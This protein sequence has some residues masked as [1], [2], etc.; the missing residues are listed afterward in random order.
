MKITFCGAVHE[1]T[2]SCY[3]IQADN[4]SKVLVD[5]GIFQ[6]GK[7]AEDK[8]E[9]DFPFSASEIS[10]VVVTHAHFDHVGRLPKLYK[11][12]FRGKVW[13]TKPTL[14]LSAI[15]LRDAVHLME[16]EAKRHHK[17]PIYGKDEV[18][19]LDPYWEATQYHKEIEIAPGISAY[20]FDAGH[21]LGS[22][23]IRISADNQVVVFS[24]D[25]GNKPTPLLNDYECI[26]GADIVV[27][28][29]T[30][31]N[32]VH[33][34]IKSRDLILKN[35]IL[36]VVRNRGVLLIPSFALERTQE[37]LY[38]IHH[39]ID[40]NE[41]PKVP[42]FLDSPL[43][44]AATEIFARNERYFSGEIQHE[45]NMGEQLFTFP[46]LTFTE[47][48]DESKNILN[49]PAP[50]VIIAGSGMMNGGRIL[51]HLKN[52]L[53]QDTTTLLIIGYQVEGSLGR[54][55]HQG[56][57]DVLIYGEEIRV[58]ADVQSCGAFSGHADYPRLM[59]WLNCFEKNPPR[60]I[61]VTHGELNSAISF[62]QA[63]EDQIGIASGVP[64]FGET[65]DLSNLGNVSYK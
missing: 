16:D 24:G 43:A 62:S 52:Y 22:A 39:L 13:C 55:L 7:Y 20:L 30:Y 34:P 18:E 31:G 28:E 6:G 44:I 56:E 21:I 50:K 10:A 65:V 14:E 2:G 49:V 12:G 9:M 63:I 45:I 23:S 35:A 1:V 54:K 17:E 26:N 8:N 61:F 11:E 37:L 46:G 53:E 32:R 58:N 5:C 4:G 27:V 3:Y 25:L 15:T 29:S 19:G 60:K 42:I 33:E 64:E 59:N 51:H 41:I 47:T 36:E 38:Q 48:S 40:N 57:K